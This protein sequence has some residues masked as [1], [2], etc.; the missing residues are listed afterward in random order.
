MNVSSID[1]LFCDFWHVQGGL[2]GVGDMSQELHMVCGLQDFNV[3]PGVAEDRTQTF[4]ELVT[5]LRKLELKIVQHTWLVKVVVWFVF[6]T[7][8]TIGPEPSFLACVCAFL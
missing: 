8:L 7:K 2:E 6:L 4:L 3:L 1:Q 5:F